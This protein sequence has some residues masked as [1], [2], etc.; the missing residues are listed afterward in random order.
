MNGVPVCVQIL[1]KGKA[2]SKQVKCRFQWTRLSMDQSGNITKIKLAGVN[3]MC[4]SLVIHVRGLALAH[5]GAVLGVC[6]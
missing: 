6:G 1:A 4:V 3:L 5:R 2:A